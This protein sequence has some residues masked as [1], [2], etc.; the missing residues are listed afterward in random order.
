MGLYHSFMQ[1]SPELLHTS[2]DQI[3]SRTILDPVGSHMFNLHRKK[4]NYFFLAKSRYGLAIE[5]SVQ[6][7]L[8]SHRFTI[9]TFII[10][11]IKRITGQMLR[12]RSLS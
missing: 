5:E 1:S 10:E 8:W 4:K 9:L 12:E 7:K 6:T 11:V 3:N 2:V